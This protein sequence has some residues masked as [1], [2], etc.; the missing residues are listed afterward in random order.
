MISIIVELP[1]DSKVMLLIIGL[2]KVL[3]IGAAEHNRIFA[4]HQDGKENPQ[5]YF[6]HV[7]IIV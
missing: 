1:I 3:L 5:K 7:N 6:I 2:V 4:H